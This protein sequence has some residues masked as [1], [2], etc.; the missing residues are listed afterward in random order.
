VVNSS[1]SCVLTAHR[2]CAVVPA[3]DHVRAQQDRPPRGFWPEWTTPNIPAAARQRGAGRSPAPWTGVQGLSQCTLRVPTRAPRRWP[4]DRGMLNERGLSRS[5]D[6]CNWQWS[7]TETLLN[8]LGGACREWL[9]QWQSA[10]PTCLEPQVGHEH[11]VYDTTV[12]RRLLPREERPTLR[13][14]D[15]D[16]RCVFMLAYMAQAMRSEYRHLNRDARTPR[17]DRRRCVSRYVGKSV[18]L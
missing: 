10:V 4:A 8:C 9:L 5:Q 13:C 12:S 14:N 11:A 7:S 17:W 16:A 1:P 18:T 3:A 15:C 2:D 6:A